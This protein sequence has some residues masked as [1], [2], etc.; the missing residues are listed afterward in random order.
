LV[1]TV[2]LLLEKIEAVQ[3]ESD[4]LIFLEIFVIFNNPLRITVRPF[5]TS[6]V[7]TI[8][9]FSISSDVS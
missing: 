5:T 3:I 2:G 7:S 8:G 1:V 9:G 4:S 6:L